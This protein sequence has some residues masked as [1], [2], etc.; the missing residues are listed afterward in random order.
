MRRFG[1]GGGGGDA[2]GRLSPLAGWVGKELRGVPSPDLRWTFDTLNLGREL[3]EAG[4][5]VS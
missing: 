4:D 1:I 5:A 2:C 3:H